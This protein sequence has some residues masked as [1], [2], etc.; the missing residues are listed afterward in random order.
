MAETLGLGLAAACSACFQ[1]V[2]VAAGLASAVAVVA[3]AGSCDLEDQSVAAVVG[4]DLAD[5]AESHDLVVEDHSPWGLGRS[6]AEADH[7]P[8]HSLVLR[9]ADLEIRE[10]HRGLGIAGAA[11]TGSVV[12]L[13][14]QDAVV[15]ET[16][17][18][19]GRRTGSA[20]AGQNPVVAVVDQTVHQ[21]SECPCQ[22]DS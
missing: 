13:G 3:A 8:F 11:E 20:A 18:E 12:G 9:R 19:E 14:N 22:R 17:V 5:L 4:M 7:I 1:W 15:A 2:L 21:V 6:Q 16:V 10:R